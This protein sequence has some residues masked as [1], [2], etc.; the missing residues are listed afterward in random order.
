VWKQV[1][2]E[3]K[4]KEQE[5]EEMDEKN[6]EETTDVDGSKLDG[7]GGIDINGLEDRLYRYVDEKFS[8]LKNHLDARLTVIESL[9]RSLTSTVDHRGHE[10]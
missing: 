6:E 1:E 3:E 4:E 10:E 9:I 7:V 8:A 2:E 5:K